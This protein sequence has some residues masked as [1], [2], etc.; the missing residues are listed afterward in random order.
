MCQPPAGYAIGAIDYSSQE[1][2]LGAV[3]SND[4]KMIE[5]YAEGDVYLYYGKGIGLIPKDGTKATHGKER[6]LCKSTVL[7]LSYLMTKVGLAKKL[8]ADTGKVVTEE[9][10]DQ[11]VTKY[12]LLFSGFSSWRNSVI[13]HYREAKQIKLP[14]GWYMFGDN[15]SFRSAANMPLQGAGACIMRKAVALAQDA[16][17]NIIFTL[18][19]ALYI[20][21]KSEYIKDA[22]DL[23]AKC[24]KEAF[25]FYFKEDQKKHAALIRLDGKVWGP[26]ME[27]GEIITKMNF[28]L[29]SSKL[30]IDNRAKSEYDRFHRFFHESPNIEML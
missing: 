24:M 17:L 22:M 6:D 18:H 7:G 13:A 15:P 4:P 29:D 5:A 2:L 12:D 28:K 19:D 25:I 21:E 9:E 14:D 10:A 30:H 3:C 27:E 16:G 26:D 23:L 11:L 20:M 8:T 1:F